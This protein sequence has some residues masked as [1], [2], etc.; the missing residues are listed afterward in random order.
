MGIFQG[1]EYV[2]EI[3]STCILPASDPPGTYK[4]LTPRTHALAT[5]VPAGHVFRIN[6]GAPLPAGT[7]AVLMVEDTRLADAD[8]AGEE[9]E[10][11]AL[12]QVAPGE[13][14]RKSGSDVRKGDLA[15]EKGTVVH[16]HGGEIG[17]MAFVGRQKVSVCAK[18]EALGLM[19][20]VGVGASHA[21]RS[22]LE[23][24]KRAAGHS[25]ATGNGRR[26]VGR[27]LGHEPPV[28]AGRSGG[29]GIQS[30]GP[31]Y[32]ARRVEHPLR[33]GYRALPDLTSL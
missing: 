19:R 28:A 6:T 16:A 12:A 17:T 18:V 13:N 14:V 31:R 33:F 20:I 29:H 2:N 11:E 22:D 1:K 21:S 25:D 23:H 7:D 8:A 4:V 5:P 26:R 15:L 10:V 27:D 30:A 24:G 9:L 3:G 32:R